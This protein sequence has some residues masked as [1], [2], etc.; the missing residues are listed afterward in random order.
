METEKCGETDSDIGSM[1]FQRHTRHS[2]DEAEVFCSG[3]K[4][5]PN[6]S[7]KAWIW[8]ISNAA[9]V[10]FLVTAAYVQVR[11]AQWRH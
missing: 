6:W 4:Q 8:R 3:K 2:K 11:M 7:A 1:T 5:N 9:M 10:V